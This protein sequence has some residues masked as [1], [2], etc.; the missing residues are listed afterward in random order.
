MAD[1]KRAPEQD[2]S[3]GDRATIE[4]ELK[5]MAETQSGAGATERPGVPASGPR[6]GEKN[7]TATPAQPVDQNGQTVSPSASRTGL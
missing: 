3:E 4:R 6:G 1:Q 5:R 2:A 7:A